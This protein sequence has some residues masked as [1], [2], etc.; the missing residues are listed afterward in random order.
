[1]KIEDVISLIESG[2]IETGLAQLAKLEQTGDHETTY[3]V[4]QAYYQLGHL[5]NAKRLID[6]LIMLYPDEGE[7]Y[8]FAAEILIDS[9]EED[10]AIDMLL[11]IKEQDSAFLQAQLFLADL[12]QM[13]GLEEVA[14]QKLLKAA[15]LAPN[16]EIVALGLGE[17]Y[18]ERGDYQKSIPYLKK[19]LHSSETFEAYQ[20]ELRLAEAFSASGEFEEALIYYEK[21]LKK[22][23]ELSA[24]FGYGYTAFQVEDY[25]KAIVQ[26]KKLKELDPNYTSLYP[27]LAKSYEAMH[28]LDEALHTINEG[29]KIDEYNEALYTQAAK[30]SFKMNN[31]I[32]GENYL[33]DVIAL[34]PSH[35]EAVQMLSSF[36]RTEERF[37]ELL[38]LLSHVKELGE[39]DPFHTWYEGVA[40]WK[41]EEFE[42][43]YQ[44]FQQVNDHFQ[45]DLDFLEDYGQFLIEYGKRELGIQILKKVITLDS[46]RD[47]LVE[48]VEQ[49][50]NS[51]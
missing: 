48:I 21:G 29:L 22:T 26:F 51:Y 7:L 20:V 14:E 39:D 28:N 32:A 37:E 44:A 40:Q 46:S 41:E 5:T 38:E 49:L 34:N 33:R 45:E 36:L 24:Y 43:A 42:K 10:E 27:Y 12:Y 18:L 13:Q 3:M 6:E 25:E 31:L 19:A 4:A 30:I 1:M 50:D 17:F 16:E 23:E 11:E 8:T 9:D 2:D 35:V 15:K 47:D